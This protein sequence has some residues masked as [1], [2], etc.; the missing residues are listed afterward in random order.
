M[1][2]EVKITDRSS[3]ILQKLLSTGMKRYLKILFAKINP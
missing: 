3:E 2:V 1:S